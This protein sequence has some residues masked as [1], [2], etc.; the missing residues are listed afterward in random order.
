MGNL[1]I[2]DVATE[3]LGHVRHCSLELVINYGNDTYV[4]KVSEN[5]DRRLTIEEVQPNIRIK[6]SF[7]ETMKRY[8]ALTDKLPCHTVVDKTEP[9]T[10]LSGIRII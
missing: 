6:I 8:E 2:K 7:H 5:R 1:S 9:Y 4:R 10:F 3:R